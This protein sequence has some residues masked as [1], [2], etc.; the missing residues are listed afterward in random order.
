MFKD[1]FG[2]KYLMSIEFWGIEDI[3]FCEVMEISAEIVR[4]K[5]DLSFFYRFYGLTCFIF[6]Y[7]IRIL[8][9]FDNI[10]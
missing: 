8:S 7:D 1:F 6:P 5:Q 9:I 3:N 10:L 2:T 4:F